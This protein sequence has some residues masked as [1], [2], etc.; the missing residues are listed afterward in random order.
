MKQIEIKLHCLL[1]FENIKLFLQTYVLHIYINILAK[2]RLYNVNLC[3]CTLNVRLPSF[4]N[5]YLWE[6]KQTQLMLN[7]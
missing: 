5:I 6:W 3:L 2:T 1:S 4:T 7:P